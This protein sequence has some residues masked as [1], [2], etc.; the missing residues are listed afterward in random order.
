M[1]FFFFFIL[2]QN[3]LISGLNERVYS[4]KRKFA[5]PAIEKQLYLFAGYFQYVI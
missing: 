4:E 5:G 3:L 2:T 1:D